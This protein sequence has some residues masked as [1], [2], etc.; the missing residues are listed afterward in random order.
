MLRHPELSRQDHDGCA[1]QD[2]VLALLRHPH[3]DAVVEFGER[4]CAEGL[5]GRFREWSVEKFSG[6]GEDDLR[7]VEHADDGREGDAEALPR[8]AQDAVAVSVGCLGEPRG[9]RRDREPGFEASHLA[10]DAH[11][12][13]RRCR[14]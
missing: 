12:A 14:Q 3:P 5:D 2:D 4:P 10:A 11:A 6:A 7:D 13:R 8:I 1:A 9:Q